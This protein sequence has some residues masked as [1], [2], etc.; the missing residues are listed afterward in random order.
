MWLILLQRALL[1]P[2][3]Q[4]RISFFQFVC[5]VRVWACVGM[6]VSECVSVCFFLL[7]GAGQ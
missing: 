1:F 3:F 7:V 6:H 5:K 2:M 4:R